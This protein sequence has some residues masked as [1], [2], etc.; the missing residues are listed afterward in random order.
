M[1]PVPR[2]LLHEGA[3]LPFSCRCSGVS[4]AHH[5]IGLVVGNGTAE[6]PEACRPTA[7]VATSRSVR[8]ERRIAQFALAL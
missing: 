2:L 7:G 5:R 6:P 1:R 4:A 8:T 3:F